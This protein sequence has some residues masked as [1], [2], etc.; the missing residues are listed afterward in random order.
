MMG[1]PQEPKRAM[2][3]DEIDNLFDSDDAQEELKAKSGGEEDAAG[4]M[5]EEATGEGAELSADDVAGVAE[6]PS[7]K[8]EGVGPEAFDGSAALALEPDAEA[9]AGA[10]PV[11][12]GQLES[13]G[14]SDGGANIDLLMDVKLPVTVELGRNSVQVKDILDFSPGSIVELNR[15]ASEPVD[16]LVNGVLVARGEVVVIEEHFGVRLTSLISPQER[17]RSLAGDS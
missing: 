17:I 10:Q 15:L 16:I 3:K 13:P 14:G 7:G 5:P 4:D 11:E 1:D 9:P 12:F 6:A 8:P 2:S